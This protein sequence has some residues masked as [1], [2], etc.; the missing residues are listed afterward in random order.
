[1]VIHD[2]G[3]HT[4]KNKKRATYR[5][6]KWV[7]PLTG[8]DIYLQTHKNITKTYFAEFSTE[9]VSQIESAIVKFS[10]RIL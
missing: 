7:R 8:D 1:M 3:T 4:Q 9:D 2:K 6:G 10:Q 5:G